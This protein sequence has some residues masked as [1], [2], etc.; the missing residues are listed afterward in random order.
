MFFSRTP[1]FGNFQSMSVVV[2]A[3]SPDLDI[4]CGISNLNTLISETYPNLN[5]F[6]PNNIFPDEYRLMGI[7]NITPTL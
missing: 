1:K 3:K 6:E 7:L 4:F 5:V 2:L